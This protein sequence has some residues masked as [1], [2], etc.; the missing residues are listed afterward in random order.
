MEYL[1]RVNIADRK[2]LLSA[3]T[4][5]LVLKKFKGKILKISGGLIYT[6]LA[7][8]DDGKSVTETLLS[9]KT[10]E[11]FVT[12]TSPSVIR[13]FEGLCSAY[14][15]DEEG[16]AELYAGVDMEVKINDGRAGRDFMT[17]EVV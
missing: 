4:S 8:S 15:S 12:T 2:E 1:K 13:S 6:Q 14:E 11:G 7:T 17:L 3:T 10:N 9:L 5:N 16:K